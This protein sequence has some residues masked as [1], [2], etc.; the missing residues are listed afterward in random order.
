MASVDTT[1][2]LRF[3]SA[4]RFGSIADMCGAPTHV[5]FIPNSDRESGFPQKVCP[6]YSRKQ[7]CALQLQM[8][9]K[10]HKR[11]LSL[12]SITSSAVPSSDGGIVR[13]SAAAVLRLITNSYFVGDCTGRSDGFSP[14]RIRST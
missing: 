14:L 13:P 9:A 6:L 10:G 8:S 2:S 3:D 4:S 12:H 7:T 5:R 1:T 11:T